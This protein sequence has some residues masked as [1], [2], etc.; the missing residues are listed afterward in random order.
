VD[1]ASRARSFAAA[2]YD[3]DAD[4]E[5]PAEVAALVGDSN[6]ELWTA[7]ILHDLVEDTDV[8]LPQIAAEFG[9]RVAALVAAMTEDASISDYGER[10][11]EHRLRARD[12][13]ADVARLFVADKLS[14]ARRMRRGQKE[15]D[16]K[17]LAH[18][19][20]TLETMRKAYPELPLLSDLERELGVRAAD[21]PLE[22]GPQAH[23]RG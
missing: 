18:Y 12:A 22:P 17:K 6:Q 13:G 23:A 21:R 1:V 16:P 7:A 11:Q 4:L 8:G 20:A 9:S 10:K 3:S 14:N 15:S 2:A 5:H 19:R